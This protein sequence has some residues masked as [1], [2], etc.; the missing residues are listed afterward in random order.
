VR[1]SRAKNRKRSAR[2]AK[3]RKG[4]KLAFLPCVLEGKGGKVKRERDRERGDCEQRK[5]EVESPVSGRSRGAGGEGELHIESFEEML[6]S[7][8]N[9]A[10]EHAGRK[11]RRHARSEKEGEASAAC[12]SFPVAGEEGVC[13]CGFL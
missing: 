12:F 7:T 11:T 6:S 8:H 5:E 3:T 1:T 13:A 2:C 10:G 4:D 9:S